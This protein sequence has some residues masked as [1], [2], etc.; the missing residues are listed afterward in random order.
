[1]DFYVRN[2]SMTF[3]TLYFLIKDLVEEG[4]ESD[5]PLPLKKQFPTSIV[6]APDPVDESDLFVNPFLGYTNCPL[7]GRYNRGEYRIGETLFQ[8]GFK[9]HYN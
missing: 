6:F 1:M 9:C 4:M 7:I 5:W 8:I 3:M 2:G